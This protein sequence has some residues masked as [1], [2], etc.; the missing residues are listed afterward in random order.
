[1][2]NYWLKN[3]SAKAELEVC[4]AGKCGPPSA[5]ENKSSGNSPLQNRRPQ[6]SVSYLDAMQETESGQDPD[7]LWMETAAMQSHGLCMLLWV[8]A[9]ERGGTT[10]PLPLQASIWVF[11]KLRD[12]CGQ[13]VNR[14]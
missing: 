6:N 12:V 5:P 9:R 8:P 14:K 7:V 3:T 1:M 11:P 4:I 13:V 10:V 2:E